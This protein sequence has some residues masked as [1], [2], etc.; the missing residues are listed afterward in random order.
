VGGR[1][2]EK[3]GEREKCGERFR[4]GEKEVEEKRCRSE[5]KSTPSVMQSRCPAHAITCNHLFT[6][7]S[8]VILIMITSKLKPLTHCS[9]V[10]CPIHCLPCCTHPTHHY[11]SIPS[12]HTLLSLP[13]PLPPVLL[14]SSP[15][16]FFSLASP[17]FLSLPFP[18]P[19][20]SS[21]SPLPPFCPSPYLPSS[22]SLLPLSSTPSAYGL[23]CLWIHAG[24]ACAGSCKCWESSR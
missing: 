9:T 17:P 8:K 10:T 18:L 14:S 13:F 11:L 16:L 19:P 4:Q 12:V 6:L 23:G 5:H 22:L 24:Q 2:G 3:R 15:S 20:F 1:E 7:P 21:L